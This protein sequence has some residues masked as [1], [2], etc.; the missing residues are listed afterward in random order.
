M[1][2]AGSSAIIIMDLKIDE[3]LT[4]S[5]LTRTRHG[6]ALREWLGS[7]AETHREMQLHSS[8]ILAKP[9]GQIV[10]LI[11]HDAQENISWLLTTTL[12]MYM[13]MLCSY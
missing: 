8:V 12:Y 1:F 5:L 11:M 3:L 9:I 2:S 13:I 7:A 10:S 6:H 4:A